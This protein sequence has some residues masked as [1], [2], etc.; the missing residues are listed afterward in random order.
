MNE[1]LDKTSGDP[2]HR[3]SQEQYL[4]EVN[5]GVEKIEGIL[6]AIKA[7]PKDD[8]NVVALRAAVQFIWDLAMIH[9]FEGVETISGKLCCTISHSRA[10]GTQLSPLL[11]SRVR[12]A[13]V[14]IREVAEL[15]STMEQHLTVD[16]VS[17]DARIHQNRIQ[18]RTQE[19]SRT[20]DLLVDEDSST[21]DDDQGE[22][23]RL[24]ES[25]SIVTEED[26]PNLMFDIA[27]L[28]SVMTL[29]EDLDLPSS[30]DRESESLLPISK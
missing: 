24:G 3:L 25:L 29:T 9:G 11:L 18:D 2:T 4:T 20:I 10:A 26:V 8:L 22:D 15:E 12:G 23:E 5:L 16:T 21:F 28:D 1:C 7:E 13:L 17:Q 6:A 30:P 14:V 27:E 19:F